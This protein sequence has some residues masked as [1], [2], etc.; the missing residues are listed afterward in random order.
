MENLDNQLENPVEPMVNQEQTLFS[1]ADR[2][3]MSYA[4]S[5]LTS[6]SKWMKFFFVLMIIS[7]VFMVVSGL[8]FALASPM[9]NDMQTP[10]MPKMPTAVLGVIY[11]VGGLLN[12]FPA[13]YM[14]RIS[15]T[16]ERT[17]ESSDND[18]MVDFLK[19]NK[20]L[21]KFLGILTIVMIGLS[22]VFVPIMFAVI[23]LSVL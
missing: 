18:A 6:I 11:I 14:N 15:K 22:I 23:G 8:I 19:N 9:F 20:S 13:I 16:A 4:C 12:V 7:I 3:R 2:D 17:V 10:G 5:Y 1:E 21:W